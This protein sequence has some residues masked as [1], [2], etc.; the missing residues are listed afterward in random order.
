MHPHG[1]TLLA[2]CGPHETAKEIRP[3][4]RQHGALSY[5]IC[6]AFYYCAQNKIENVTHELI[7]RH[8]YAEMFRVGDQHP[9]LIGTD[10]STLRG[11]EVGRLDARSTFEIIQ[12]S[13]DQKIRMNAGF[14][15][16]ACT[17]DEYGVYVHA[18]AKELVTRITITDVEAVQFVARY[19]S[20][21]SSEANGSQIKIGYRV[22]LTKLA[23]PRAYVK[24]FPEANDSWEE[25]L[26]E[27]I[28][29]QRLPSDEPASVDIPCF[30]V[31][32]DR[33]QYI[34][35]DTKGGVIL[36]LSPLISSS[37]SV[38]EQ[39]FIIL[40]HHSK[41]TFV[42]ALDNRRTNSLTDSDFMITAKEQADHLDSYKPR[43]SI[44]IPHDSKLSIE[45]QNLTQEVLYF[46]ILNLTPLRQ[47]KRLYP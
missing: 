25:S 6:K 4:G 29:L 5:L 41:Y 32:P 30:S 20:I 24:L 23:R 17:G 9:I 2:A 38:S 34:I 10:K 19:T 12:V 40:E 44:T 16:G 22:I 47:I 43:S 31:T 28:W 13:V 8:V 33:H 18:E 42:Q 1:Y 45:F 27:N 46:T 26:E 39:T 14:L 36:D 7:H 3:G 11:A 37:P 15:H 21:M 35:L